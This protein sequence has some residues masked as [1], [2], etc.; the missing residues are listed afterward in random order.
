MILILSY[1]LFDLV[2]LF[3]KAFLKIIN[4]IT[5]VFKN[6]S[7]NKE[8][9]KRELF[10]ITIENQVILKRLYERQSSYSVVKWEKQRLQNEKLMK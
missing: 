10:R 2:R 4:F 9:R 3:T 8:I 5:A 1:H 7:L 6:R